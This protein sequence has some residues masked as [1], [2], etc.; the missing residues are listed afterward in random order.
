MQSF[1]IHDTD[2][3]GLVAPGEGQITVI[4]GAIR[5]P[6]DLPGKVTGLIRQVDPTIQETLSIG[7]SYAELSEVLD[8]VISEVGELEDD[9]FD[10]FTEAIGW[11]R[12]QARIVELEKA[13][14]EVGRLYPVPVR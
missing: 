14:V 13:A 7:S 6:A 5:C 11:T 12:L 8:S 9:L 10:A 4:L 3:L 2:D 1:I